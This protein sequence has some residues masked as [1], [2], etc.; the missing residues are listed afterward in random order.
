MKLHVA[1][2]AVAVSAGPI[3][4]QISSGISPIP[5]IT[6]T[7]V[8]PDS[9]SQ[10]VFL[11]PNIADLTISYPASLGGDG[12]A[13][14]RTTFK[15]R[16]LNQVKPIVSVDVVAESDGTYL[17]SYTIQNDV[18]ARDGIKI[19]VS[20]NAGWRCS[21]DCDSPVLGRKTGARPGQP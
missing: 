8:I 3:D 16:M 19:M 6:S 10:F 4:A 1:L 11:G 18:S 7:T 21:S 20:C 15:I 9:S 13:N 12:S 14:G 5:T 2:L 17:Y